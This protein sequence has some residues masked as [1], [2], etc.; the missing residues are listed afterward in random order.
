VHPVVVGAGQAVFRGVVEAGH[1]SSCRPRPHPPA[2]FTSPIASELPP[3]GPAHQSTR[4]PCEART[5]SL[6]ALTQRRSHDR[7]AG[8]G[9]VTCSPSTRST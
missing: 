8:P 4:S 3:S 1:W 7:T 9:G 6:F 2:A 5:E